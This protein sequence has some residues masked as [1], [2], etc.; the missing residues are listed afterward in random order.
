VGACCCHRCSV[1]DRVHSA[2]CCIVELHT[3]PSTCCCLRSICQERSC[4]CHPVLCL[5]LLLLLPLCWHG[6]TTSCY[7]ASDDGDDD[8]AGC[9]DDGDEGIEDAA[10]A[11]AKAQKHKGRKQQGEAA[12]EENTLTTPEHLRQKKGD[13]TFAV[14]PL[15]HTMS[16]LF[17][18]GGAKGERRS[19]PDASQAPAMPS[20][21]F[22]YRNAVATPL[23]TCS[24]NPIN[25]THNKSIN[26]CCRR[27]CRCCAANIP[28]YAHGAAGLLL[29]N[30]SVFNGAHIMTAPHDVPEQ[31]FSLQ[32]APQQDTLLDLRPLQQQLAACSHASSASQGAAGAAASAGPMLTPGLDQ[33]YNLLEQTRKSLLM[34]KQQQQQQQDQQCSNVDVAS[35]M[36]LA[37]RKLWG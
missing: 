23:V 8:E 17:D 18:E 28:A 7:A 29:L 22:F 9:E 34:T 26:A 36:Q 21:P 5:R 35:I 12:D 11:A 31:Q 3:A 15:F 19:L 27:Q 2:F 10:A 16:A 6:C 20:Q 24:N 13:T 4:C 1:H 14:D 37:T 33:L 30:R 32:P 25:H